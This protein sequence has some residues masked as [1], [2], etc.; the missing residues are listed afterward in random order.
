MFY[1]IKYNL[2]MKFHDTKNDTQNAVFKGILLNMFM[3]LYNGRCYN[4]IIAHWKRAYWQA[5]RNWMK[6]TC[7]KA[8]KL[9]LNFKIGLFE[10]LDSL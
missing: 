4:N 8:S 3:F 2:L 5:V 10:R 6:N 9:K 7:I 1:N